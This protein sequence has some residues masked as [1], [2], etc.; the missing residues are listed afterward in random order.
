MSESIDIE[1]KK[2]KSFYEPQS[3]AI[4]GASQ[5]PDK[6]GYKILFNLKRSGYQGTVV[7]VNPNADSILDFKNYK[8][9]DEFN[10][11]IDLSVIVVPRKSVM[12]AVKASIAK[13]AKTVSVI[14]AGFKEQDHEGAEL[15]N[16]L[17]ALCKESGCVS[18]GT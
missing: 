4:I 3:V 15:E 11:T 13:G 5:N 6:V 16:Q 1:A 10:G 17:A 9:L 12:E 18:A 8:S 2:L 7:P 14:T